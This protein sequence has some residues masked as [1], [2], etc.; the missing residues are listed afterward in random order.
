MASNNNSGNGV[1]TNTQNNPYPQSPLLD[2]QTKRPTRAWQQF[3]LG[4]LNFTSAT[5]AT[6]GAAVLPSNPVGFINI[7]VNGQSYKV[8]YYNL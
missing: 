8:P 4:I 6:K 5:T 2:E 3:F 7:T 1:W